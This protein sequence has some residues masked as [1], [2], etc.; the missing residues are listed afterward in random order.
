[1]WGFLGL[2]LLALFVLYLPNTIIFGFDLAY[3]AYFIGGLWVSF[4]YPEL[5]QRFFRKLI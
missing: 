5:Y 1:M 2:G 4:I 3:V